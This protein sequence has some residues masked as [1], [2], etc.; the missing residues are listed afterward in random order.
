MDA[1]GRIAVDDNIPHETSTPTMGEMSDDEMQSTSRQIVANA[2]AS[3]TAEDD[4]KKE[5]AN[6]DSIDYI[7]E[8]PP[9]EPI[10]QDERYAIVGAE[11]TKKTI[12]AAE[13]LTYKHTVASAVQPADASAQAELLEEPNANNHSSNTVP[14][15]DIEALEVPE[16]QLR[17]EEIG[18]LQAELQSGNARSKRMRK[19]YVIVATSL[20]CV[21]LGVLVWVVITQRSSRTFSRKEIRKRA[22]FLSPFVNSM[23]LSG[24]ELKYPP[25]TNTAEEK[26]LQWLVEEDTHLTN[27]ENERKIVQRFALADLYFSNGP[28]KLEAIEDTGS[29]IL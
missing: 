1:P 26:A 10:Q 16:I 12:F 19:F 21:L 25:Q 29:D 28:W 5:T 11:D 4:S 27:F 13:R 7:K 22:Q 17:E 23:S 20:G 8:N 3:L 24:A 14:F 2:G 9:T 15:A 6:D 18:V